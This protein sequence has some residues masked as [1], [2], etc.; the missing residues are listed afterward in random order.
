[1]K[2]CLIAL[3]S[4]LLVIASANVALAKGAIPGGAQ[5]GGPGL[6]GTLTFGDPTGKGGTHS[7]GD[8]NILAADTKLLDTLFEGNQIAAPETADLGPRYTIVWTMRQEMG[9]HRTFRLRSDLYPYAKGGILVHT[10]GGKRIREGDSTFTLRRGW[11][12]ANPI[13][14]Q[15][16]Q[17]WGLPKA[18][19]VGVEGTTSTSAAS[20]FWIIPLALL[21]LIIIAGFRAKRRTTTV[22]TA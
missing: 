14:K 18:P 5:M 22:R 3:A 9:G 19:R 1:M 10:H 21:A 15:N 2:R 12:S 20:T 16:L 6:K 8:I 17:A 7:D 11:A 4:V 13:L